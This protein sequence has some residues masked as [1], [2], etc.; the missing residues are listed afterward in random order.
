MLTCEK[1]KKGSLHTHAHT[2]DIFNSNDHSAGQVDQLTAQMACPR[3]SCSTHW[4]KRCT[5]CLFVIFY[6]ETKFWLDNHKTA[7]SNSNCLVMFINGDT[8]E[9]NV[10][11]NLNTHLHNLLTKDKIDDI[12]LWKIGLWKAYLHIITW[13]KWWYI[14]NYCNELKGWTIKAVTIN[15]IIHFDVIPLMRHMRQWMFVDML[16][17]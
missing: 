10:S 5:P 11:S 3:H 9:A 17:Q 15:K 13:I 4:E 2:H 14:G 12:W 16:S 7:V 8:F 6:K 1:C